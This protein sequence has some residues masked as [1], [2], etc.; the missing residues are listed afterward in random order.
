M[1]FSTLLGF[2]IK[3]DFLCNNIFKFNPKNKKNENIE[4][5]RNERDGCRFN[6]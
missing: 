3:F 4:Q 2:P 5:K 1:V 6:R